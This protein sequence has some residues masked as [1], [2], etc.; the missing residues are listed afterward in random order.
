MV[1]GAD[2]H[3]CQDGAGGYATARFQ[4]SRI[5]QDADKLDLTTPTYSN[6]PFA[7]SVLLDKNVR[8]SVPETFFN[9]P[10]KTGRLPGFL[11]TVACAGNVHLIWFEPNMRAYLYT[12][13]QLQRSL[14][15]RPIV[16]RKDGVI[17]DVRP[18]PGVTPECSQ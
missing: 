2:A 11:D 18:R 13:E 16:E 14:I 7:M 10:T 6:D 4:H 15:L 1:R 12:P 5:L 8:L 9:S 3:V 17:Y